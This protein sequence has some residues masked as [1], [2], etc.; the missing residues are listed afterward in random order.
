LLTRFR[1]ELKASE[2]V[3]HK[4]LDEYRRDRLGASDAWSGRK[5][6]TSTR[7]ATDNAQRTM[8]FRPAQATGQRAAVM[9][10]EPAS[11][12][13]AP[14]HVPHHEDRPH[15]VPEPAVPARGSGGFHTPA[16]GGKSS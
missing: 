11:R 8:P 15:A 3:I 12:V 14:A 16:H 13:T 9:N 10:V 4:T 6:V 5:P 1:S 7:S 2:K